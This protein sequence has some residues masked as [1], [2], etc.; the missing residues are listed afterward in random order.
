MLFCR[1]YHCAIFMGKF[2]FGEIRIIIIIKLHLLIRKFFLK[3]RLM[4][5][6]VF[7]NKKQCHL[8]NYLKMLHQQRGKC[9]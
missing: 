4:R 7:L 2:I 9:H 8:R 6:V 3:N 1:K 5:D